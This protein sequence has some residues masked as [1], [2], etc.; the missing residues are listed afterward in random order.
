[1]ESD[2]TKRIPVHYVKVDDKHPHSNRGSVCLE[3]EAAGQ[4]V[5]Y[6]LSGSAC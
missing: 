2:Y 1:M 6:S 5:S 4:M 3:L